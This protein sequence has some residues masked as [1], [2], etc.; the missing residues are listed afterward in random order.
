M[1]DGN[2]KSTSFR[3]SPEALSLLSKM[4]QE[5]GISQASLIELAVRE[6]AK[7]KTIAR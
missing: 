5:L 3:L 2:K 7:R 6:F 4:S 1:K